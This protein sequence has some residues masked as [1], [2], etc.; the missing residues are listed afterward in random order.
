MRAP[1]GYITPLK[2]QFRSKALSLML[3]SFFY[4][5]PLL[6]SAVNRFCPN[7]SRMPT[8]VSRVSPVLP[9]C[10][11][12]P[13]TSASNEPTVLEVARDDGIGPGLFH[14]RSVASAPV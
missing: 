9:I 7:F 6:S 5:L 3:F 13:S 1:E 8:K 11:R 10:C 12:A 14:P 4:F 2:V